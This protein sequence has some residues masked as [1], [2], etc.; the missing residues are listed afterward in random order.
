MS[1][2]HTI[3][4]LIS[5]S[6]ARIARV[7]SSTHA[8]IV[9]DYEHHEIHDACAFSVVQIDLTMAANSQLNV[10][11]T[12]ADS[13]KLIHLASDS[14]C[15]L[16]AEVDLL[17]GPTVT[18]DSGA[19]AAPVNRYRDGTLVTSTVYD[20]QTVPVINRVQLGATISADGLVI[21][22]DAVGISKKGGT[23]QGSGSRFEWVLKR[24]TTYAVRLLRG[25]DVA[26]G[27]GTLHLDWYEH[28][29]KD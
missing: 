1:F 18:A 2:I 29:A 4:G 17:E 14:S 20:L 22:S 9:M 5:D 21:S 28:T 13:D 10:C 24:N 6:V 12:T 3:G 8:L 16:A 25:A 19:S 7:D 23:T 27:I 26:S 15:T 11:F